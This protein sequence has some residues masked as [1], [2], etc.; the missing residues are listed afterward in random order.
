MSKNVLDVLAPIQTAIA[1]RLGAWTGAGGRSNESAPA[2][3]EAARAG[4]EQIRAAAQAVLAAKPDLT[5]LRAAYLEVRREAFRSPLP[6]KI[7]AR[8]PPVRAFESLDPVGDALSALIRE[9]EGAAAALE[10]E[11]WILGE[12][13]AT[14]ED[15]AA[16]TAALFPAPL[17]FPILRPVQ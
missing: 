5:A 13:W 17:E 1:A 16:R 2:A 12:R 4:R 8:L 14:A 10:F 11:E 9:A 7:P 15:H 6:R 3:I